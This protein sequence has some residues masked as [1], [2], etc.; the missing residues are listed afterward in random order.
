MTYRSS[1]ADRPI[2][3]GFVNLKN[4]NKNKITDNLQE[5]E[6]G[7]RTGG[8]A[9]DQ[10]PSPIPEVESQA[11]LKER[12]KNNHQ[13]FELNLP[14]SRSWLH[15]KINRNVA[16]NKPMVFLKKDVHSYIKP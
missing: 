10:E 15:P 4:L 16:I 1:V 12:L 5:E 11:M 7:S 13:Y 3:H 14:N 9:Q 6:Q 8:Q 2:E